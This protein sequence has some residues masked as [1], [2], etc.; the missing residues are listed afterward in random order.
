[1]PKKIKSK[2]KRKLE[3]EEKKV[4]KSKIIWSIVVGFIMIASTIGFVMNFSSRETIKYN[5]Y[6]FTYSQKYKKFLTRYE[7][8]ILLFTYPPTALENES[9]LFTRTPKIYIGFNNL[10][11][12]QIQA[13]GFVI[14]DLYNLYYKGIMII[15]MNSTQTTCTDLTLIID[16]NAKNLTIKKNCIYLPLNELLP[17]TIDYIVY[18]YFN[19]IIPNKK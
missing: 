6:E 11:Q 14:S 1:M 9:I 12:E 10:T 13:L 3:K 16:K 8:K 2:I 19:I 15:K 7:G 4:D 5:N 17:R 18:R